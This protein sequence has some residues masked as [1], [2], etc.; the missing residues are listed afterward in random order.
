MSDARVREAVE[1]ME[2]WL[3]D[4][5]WQPDLEALTRWDDAFRFAVAQAEKGR[6]WPE[7]VQRAHEAGRRLEG[8]SEVMAAELGLLK[9]RLQAQDQGHRALKGYRAS[10]R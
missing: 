9:A 8:R 5:A 4:A 3:E 10:S 2:A 1:Q 7:L 6:G